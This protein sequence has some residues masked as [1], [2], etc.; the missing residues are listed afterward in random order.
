MNESA[1]EFL[2]QAL[3]MDARLPDASLYLA[4][5]LG[6]LGRIDEGREAFGRDRARFVL[7]PRRE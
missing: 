5:T 4:M 2:Q 3:A 7:R 1:L 6:N